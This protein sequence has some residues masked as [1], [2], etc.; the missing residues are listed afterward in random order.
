M[1]LTARTLE[2]GGIATVIIGSAADI[3][4]YCGVPRYLHNDF[5][6]GNPLGKPWDARMQRQ[7]LEMA[8]ALVAGASQPTLMT[9]PFR[10]AED[11]TWRDVYMRISEEK[12]AELRA[13]GEANRAERLANKAKGLTRTKT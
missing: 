4:S 10:W 2:A 5:P 12:M 7:T 9:T 13:A 3:V 6:L 1:S 11:E 8:L